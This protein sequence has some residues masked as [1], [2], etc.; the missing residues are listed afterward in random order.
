[1]LDAAG[2]ELE[3]RHARLLL[4]SAELLAAISILKTLAIQRERINGVMVLA[5]SA[6]ARAQ[7]SEKGKMKWVG[8]RPAATRTQAHACV[9]AAAAPSL[10]TPRRESHLRCR[11]L[12]VGGGRRLLWQ[13]RL[14]VELSKPVEHR[15][16]DRAGIL[17]V[18]CPAATRAPSCCWSGLPGNLLAACWRGSSVGD[19]QQCWAWR[20]GKRVVC[21]S[22]CGWVNAW[23]KVDRAACRP[24]L[25]V[26]SAG[27]NPR[28]WLHLEDVKLE[29]VTL[30][31]GLHALAAV[32]VEG[33]KDCG[34]LIPQAAT[35]TCCDA[36]SKPRELA[37]GLAP[38]HQLVADEVEEGE[39]REGAVAAAVRQQRH[40]M[41]HMREGEEAAAAAQHAEGLLQSRH[42]PLPGAVARRCRRQHALE[43]QVTWQVLHTADAARHDHGIQRF[44]A[45]IRFEGHHAS[46]ANKSNGGAMAIARPTCKAIITHANVEP[47]EA[48]RSATG[49]CTLPG[50]M[51]GRKQS[52]IA[53]CCGVQ[54]GC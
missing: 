33:I 13:G 2:A 52:D 48:P 19:G 49:A 18:G 51:C 34:G 54:K 24:A 8:K 43:R 3:P 20:T 26:I 27:I 38:L 29:Y 46:V 23:V 53:A 30:Q 15:C 5:T 37:V 45:L 35:P 50:N 4:A 11:S 1:M 7:F 42:N 39:S 47:W 40:C 17:L 25:H 44:I 9:S 36:Y 21:T 22:E 14:Y 12:A 6:K 10:C 28:A 41:I 32:E 16:C 31:A